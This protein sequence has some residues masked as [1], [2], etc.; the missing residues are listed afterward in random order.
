[1]SSNEAVAQ[2]FVTALK[3][4][5]TKDQS[6]VFSKIIQIRKWREDLIDLAIVRKRRKDKFRSFHDFV[7]E[8]SPRSKK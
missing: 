8:H 6:S 7:A 1:M 2:I 3:S 4:L 5:S